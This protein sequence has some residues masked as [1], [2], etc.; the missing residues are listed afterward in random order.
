MLVDG[1]HNYET[2]KKECEYLDDILHDDGI[3]VFD[4]FYNKH[5]N[6]DSYYSEEEEY[7]DI[8]IATKRGK[9]TEKQGTRPAILE[10]IEKNNLANFGIRK[11]HNEYHAP[12]VTFRKNN[13]KML[14]MLLKNPPYRDFL[15]Q[16][17]NQILED[18]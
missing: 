4:D 2:V 12:V 16:I 17:K 9:K 18:D 1:D 13:L 14:N 11:N 3:V 6:T 5:A 8:V 15:S 10:Y 7:K